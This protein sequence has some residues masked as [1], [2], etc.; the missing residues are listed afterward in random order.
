MTRLVGYW[1]TLLI[2]LSGS[3]LEG[4]VRF[5]DFTIA[6]ENAAAR[7]TIVNGIEK[8]LGPGS[9]AIKNEAGDLILVSKDGAKRVRFDVNRPYPH[10]SPH[11]HVDELINGEWVKSGQIY[12]TDVP[13]R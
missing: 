8:Y 9:R 4:K 13:H 1:L 6:A 11:A 2:F 10:E 5:G 7:T 12:P 3:V